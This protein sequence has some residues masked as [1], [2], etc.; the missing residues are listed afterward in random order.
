M[1]FKKPTPLRRAVFP[2]PRRATIRQERLAQLHVHNLTQLGGPVKNKKQLMEEAG[3]A[4]SAGFNQIAQSPQFIAQ[5]ARALKKMV[6]I[7]DSSLNQ[8]QIKVDAG[9]APLNHLTDAFDKIQKN[10]HLI[11]GQ[12]TENKAI[13]IQISEVVA[14]KN[15]QQEKE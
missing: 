1:P 14:Q 3:Y 12:S 9:D 7:R 11:T 15:E 6:S 2:K 8:I 13:A 10:I 4:S 5:T